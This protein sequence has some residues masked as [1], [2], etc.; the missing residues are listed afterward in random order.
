MR[1][2]S[3][4]ATHP[5]AG[6]EQAGSGTNAC[7]VFI[8]ELEDVARQLS[9]RLS[10]HSGSGTLGQQANCQ[11]HQ[12]RFVMQVPAAV[13]GFG[14]ESVMPT[15]RIVVGAD[16]WP[17]TDQVAGLQL[18]STIQFHRTYCRW[19]RMR[20]SP[21]LAAFSSFSILSLMTSAGR[22]Q[23]QSFGRMVND[24][25]HGVAS[26][27]IR[28]SLLSCFVLKLKLILRHQESS[29]PV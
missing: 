20:S 24:L 18:P 15:F 5:R 3:L 28:F 22:A 17:N 21:S 26:T 19:S 1:L 27:C 16:C 11:H 29:A 12:L 4:T 10:L 25:G 13:A 9:I 14:V 6:T 7:A 23:R 8:R 2:S